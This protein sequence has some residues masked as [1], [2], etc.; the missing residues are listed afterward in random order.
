G[1]LPISGPRPPPGGGPPGGGPPGGGPPGGALPRR[2]SPRPA[3]GGGIWINV[4]PLNPRVVGSVSCAG[5]SSLRTNLSGSSQLISNS[6]GTRLLP[7]IWRV[8]PVAVNVRTADN[9]FSPPSASRA[10]DTT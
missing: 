3:P 7:R 2:P 8:R 5:I 4:S 1:A 6:I 9:F 10:D